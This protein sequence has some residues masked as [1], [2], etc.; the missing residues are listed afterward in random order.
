MQLDQNAIASFTEL[1]LLRAVIDHAGEAIAVANRE[2]RIVLS[3][4]A[5]LEILGVP[6]DGGPETWSQHYNVFRPDGSER[7]PHE[8]YP[9]YRGLRG[10]SSDDVIM[11]IRNKAR[12]DDVFI[13]AAGRPL[14]DAVGEIVGAVVSFQDVTAH[15]L[16]ERALVQRTEELAASNARLE[17]ER[18]AREDLSAFIVHDLKNPLSGVVLNARFLSRDPSLGHDEREA[19]LHVLSAAQA[20]NRMV[21]DLLDVGRS[22][23]GMLAPRIT[24]VD[25]PALIDEVAT[26]TRARV[27]DANIELVLDTR[28]LSSPT[29]RADIDLMRRVLENLAD[30]ALRYSPRGGM[31]R[32]EASTRE[33]EGSVEIAVSDAGPG[34]SETDRERVFEKYVQLTNPG[35][36]R[37]PHLRTGRG[38]GLLFCRLA[39]QCHGGT[40]WVEDAEPKGACFRFRIPQGE[41]K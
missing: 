1:E 27:G 30:N 16:A 34:I 5:A 7:F 40:I 12:G 13:S 21:M 37:G 28:S 35:E 11:L 3:N 15:T 10:E 33:A 14:R 38:L 2:G 20:I 22:E 31:I 41:T 8:E 25:L 39:V 18:R 17:R 29:I 23:D 24:D 19:A 6:A 32:I 9:L 36:P 26:T 4:H